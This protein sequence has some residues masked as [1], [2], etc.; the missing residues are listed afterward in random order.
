[1]ESSICK[2]T[3]SDGKC[4]KHKLNNNTTSIPKD[5]RKKV[6]TILC[7]E[8]VKE[9]LKL[10]EYWKG[11]KVRTSNLITNKDFYLCDNEFVEKLELGIRIKLKQNEKQR[12]N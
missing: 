5:I 2:T 11:L 10:G 3:K 1:M 6:T 8:E 9:T 7:T 4:R 12:I